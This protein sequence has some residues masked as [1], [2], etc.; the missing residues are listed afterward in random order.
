MGCDGP[1]EPVYI[2]GMRLTTDGNDFPI[3][4]FQDPNQPL[5]VTGY[6][7]YRPDDSALPAGSWPL[8]ASDVVDMDHDSDVDVIITDRKGGQSGCYWFENPGALSQASDPW[9]RHMIGGLGSE[10]MF[11]DMLDIDNDSDIDFVIEHCGDDFARVEVLQTYGGSRIVRH[12]ALNVAVE[13][14]QSS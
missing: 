9:T 2:Y 8:V 10:V 1:D 13:R 6:H 3:L 4:D 5:D 11:M 7:V 14:V 12:E